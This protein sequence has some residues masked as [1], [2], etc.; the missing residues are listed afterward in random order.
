MQSIIPPT[1]VRNNIK[2]KHRRGRAD[3]LSADG[4]DIV[5]NN[6]HKRHLQ[7]RYNTGQG[8]GEVYELTKWI[9]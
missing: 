4:Q 9:L 5:T 1:Y 6:S 7:M 3:P 8:M 2:G